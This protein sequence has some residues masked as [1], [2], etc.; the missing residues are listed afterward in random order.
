MN[1]I[2]PRMLFGFGVLFF[3]A[4]LALIIAL[5][6]V[7]QETSYGLNVVLGSLSTMSGMF[8]QWAFGQNS[9]DKDPQ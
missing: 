7:R 3:T 6:E 5:G 4:V 9:K 1:Q 2:N 8:A